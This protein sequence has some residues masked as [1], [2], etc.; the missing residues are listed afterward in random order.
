[1]VL[2]SIIIIVSIIRLHS[3]PYTHYAC[4][5]KTLTW[6]MIR[7]NS[8][9]MDI[10]NWYRATSIV[11]W[12]RALSKNLHSHNT[13]T[14]SLIPRPRPRGGKGS[15]IHWALCDVRHT[16]CSMSCDCHDNRLFGHGNAI[17]GS[18][19]V[20]HDN[21]MKATWHESD[22]HVRIQKQAQESTQCVSDPFSAWGWGLGMRL[23]N[24]TTTQHLYMY[25]LIPVW[26]NII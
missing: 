19:A 6:V 17:V 9:Q 22:W 14:T 3:F 8:S 12:T 21:H 24:Y 5:L 2:V 11:L 23:I 4:M 26:Y 7:M 16:G 18:S 25:I 15:G 1:M 10:D 13:L 20:S